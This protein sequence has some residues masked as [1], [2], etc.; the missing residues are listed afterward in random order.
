MYKCVTV[1]SPQKGS[2]MNTKS[3]PDEIS[4][5][6]AQHNIRT[7]SNAVDFLLFVLAPNRGPVKSL[8]M[9][10]RLVGV[11][12]YTTNLTL[13]NVQVTVLLCMGYCS[14]V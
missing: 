1:N 13:C 10:V 8:L 4:K 2:S 6:R 12:N 11:G 9:Y 5:T 3:I 7:Y 14:M